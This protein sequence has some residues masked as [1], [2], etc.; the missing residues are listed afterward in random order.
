MGES[1]AALLQLINAFF[2]NNLVP[3]GKSLDD[4]PHARFLCQ[5]LEEADETD[6]LERC[7]KL[8]EFALCAMELGSFG[9][10]GMAK[11]DSPWND[12][13]TRSLINRNLASVIS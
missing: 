8:V 3:D 10:A 9:P 6:D 4:F 12:C 11:D 5:L 13:W 7:T 2:N 1:A